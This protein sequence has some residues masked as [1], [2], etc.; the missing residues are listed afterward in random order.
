[1]TF[2]DPRLNDLVADNR[3]TNSPYDLTESESLLWGFNFGIATDFQTGPNGN[4]YVV[5]N[6]SGGISDGAVYEIR[7]RAVPPAGSFFTAILTGNEEVPPALLPPSATAS[8]TYAIA[9]FTLSADFTRLSY[10]VYTFGLDLDGMRTTSTTADDVTGMHI[11][12]G[13]PG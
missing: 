8:T 5:S 7:P 11:H 9:T 13:A 6:T 2:T 3:F 12:R 4:L 10:T 1:F